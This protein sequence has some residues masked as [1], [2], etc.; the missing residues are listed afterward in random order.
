MKF[1]Y[2]FDK[3]VKPFFMKGK[4]I[5]N[6]TDTQIID[7]KISCIREY[8]VNIWFY[9]KGETTIAFDAGHMDYGKIDE[10]FKAIQTDR[11]AIK[12]IF[13]THV[14]VDHAGGLDIN[15]K[16][17]FPNATIYLSRNE[18]IYLNDSH[19]RFRRLGMK[20]K[21]CVDIGKE[22][23]LL[24]DMQVLEIEGI[25]IQAVHIAGHTLG[26]MCYLIDD[27]VL[28]SG[29]CLAINEEGGYSFFDLFTQYPK[30]NKNSLKYLKS[31]MEQKNLKMICTGHSGY[32][33]EIEK[34]FKHIDKSAVASKRAPFDKRA[35]YD[36]F[37][38]DS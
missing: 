11:E 4:M 30:I 14:D 21:N 22:Y 3:N 18:E 25:K 13:L 26:H 5:A 32:T 29:D 31:L 37:K 16:K 27:E 20:I 2:F 33:K 35:P 7:E 38:E 19:H 12:H 1:I 34:A 23:T 36:L 6:P 10:A 8:D 9:K 28:I 17:I 24:H 15:S